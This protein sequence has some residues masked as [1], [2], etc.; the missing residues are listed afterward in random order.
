MVRAV[1]VYVEVYEPGV[2]AV[3]KAFNDENGS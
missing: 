1:S 3:L 2:E